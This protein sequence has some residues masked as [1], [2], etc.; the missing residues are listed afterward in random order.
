MI[1]IHVQKEKDL[2]AALK[3]YKN[4]VLKSGQLQILR[5]KQTYTKP[6]VRKREK[7]QKAIYSQKIKNG[8]D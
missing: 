4:K 8:L 5:D 2:E 3:I 6:S 7:I 1:E